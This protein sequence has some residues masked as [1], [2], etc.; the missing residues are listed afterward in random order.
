MHYSLLGAAAALALAVSPAGAQVVLDQQQASYDIAVPFGF[1]QNGDNL[2]VG[3]SFTAGLSGTFAGFQLT[4]NYGGP[5][6]SDVT[7]EVRQGAG[8]VGSLLGT[9]NQTVS[10]DYI[11][12][13]CELNFD[14]TSLNLS[15]V[16]GQQYTFDFTSA[17][18]QLG[19]SGVLGTLGDSYAGGKAITGPGYG[20][21]TDWDLRFKTY[22]DVGGGNSGVPEPASWA[23]MLAGFGLTGAMMRRRKIFLAA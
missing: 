4:S 8:L 23:M 17:T 5:M 1:S 10:C 3:Q 9:V 13:F 15:L 11:G 2:P 14:T 6:T 18:S 22:V 19:T 20:D 16:A 12:G 21:N 7:F